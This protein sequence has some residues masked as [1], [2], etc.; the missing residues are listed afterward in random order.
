[1]GTHMSRPFGHA[2]G[3]FLLA[4]LVGLALVVTA[5]HAQTSPT[6]AAGPG[7][8]AVSIAA[9]TSLT[10]PPFASVA[11]VCDETAA[12]RYTDDG[13]TTPSATVGFPVAAG[14]CFFEAVR[15][16]DFRIIGAGATMDAGYFR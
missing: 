4:A 15:L 6:S 16:S 7:Q 2:L 14:A 3:V 9:V 5:A 11:R 10:V 8:F 13:I 1:M 12:A